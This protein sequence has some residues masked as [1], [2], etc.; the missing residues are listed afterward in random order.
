VFAATPAD[1]TRVM[2]DG[3]VVARRGDAE[4]IGRDLATTIERLWR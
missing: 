1:V 3:R 4:Q 2:V